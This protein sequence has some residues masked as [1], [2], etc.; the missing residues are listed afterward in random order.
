MAP[1]VV[2]A[3]APKSKSAGSSNKAGFKI[4]S[5]SFLKTQ[6]VMLLYS[7]TYERKSPDYFAVAII[8]VD[9]DKIM[10]LETDKFAKGEGPTGELT[11]NVDI[12][13]LKNA[14]GKYV[15]AF[16]NNKNFKDVLAESKAFQIKKSNF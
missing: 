13:S 1:T 3:R 4:T 8:K 2:V 11:T 10:V 16:V 15:L 9:T 7:W 14:P 5:V 6:P 12:S